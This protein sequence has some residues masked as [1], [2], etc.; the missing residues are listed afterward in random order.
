MAEPDPPQRRGEPERPGWLGDLAALADG[1]AASDLSR[2]LPPEGHRRRSAVL[3]LFG[4]ADPQTDPDGGPD[5]LLTERAHTL[6]AHA[7][8]VAFPGGVVEPGE[9]DQ[10]A[11]LREAEEETGVDPAGIEVIRVLPTIYLPV[12]DYSVA[13]V[14]AYWRRPAPP[15]V[16]NT[17]EVARV[18]R[19]GIRELADPLSRFRVV[20]PSGFTSPGFHVRDLF[21]WGF[22][23]GLLDRVMALAG[24]EREWDAE[25]VVTLEA[26]G[27]RLV[28]RGLPASFPSPGDRLRR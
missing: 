18:E 21:V 14:L 19:V 8:Q 7:G 24:W 1:A 13:P 3:I 10:E 9:S 25:R 26:A 6:R 2:F 11:A 22:T 20:H 17:D 12:T 4:T 28:P 27:G 15:M 16:V 5:V 23:A